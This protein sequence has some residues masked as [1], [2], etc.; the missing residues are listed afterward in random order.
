MREALTHPLPKWARDANIPDMGPAREYQWPCPCPPLPPI[1]LLCCG[2]LSRWDRSHASDRPLCS[3][4]STLVHTTAKSLPRRVQELVEQSSEQ[5]SPMRRG[6]GQR[7][8]FCCHLE[9]RDPATPCSEAYAQSPRACL[10]NVMAPAN[11]R[12]GDADA[13]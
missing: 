6:T 4:R 11:L 3:V 8:T 12:E 5:H 10:D 2:T 1:L 9:C 7:P 13:K